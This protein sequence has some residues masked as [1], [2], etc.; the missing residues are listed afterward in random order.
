M[1]IVN[2]IDLKSDYSCLR[3]NPNSIWEKKIMELLGN[4]LELK[5]YFPTDDPQNV[6]LRTIINL[7]QL[8]EIKMINLKMY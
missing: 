4:P 3:V 8:S 2:G 7:Y 6:T 1:V 5:D